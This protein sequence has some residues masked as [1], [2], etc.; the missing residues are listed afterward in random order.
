MAK[1]DTYKDFI[2]YKKSSKKEKKRRDKEGRNTW[3]IPCY[4]KTIPSK[5]EKS[6]N[7]KKRD[8]YYW[9]D[10]EDNMGY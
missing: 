9:N 3:N 8:D 4:T 6:R 1:E 10:D 7:K 5:K 2:P